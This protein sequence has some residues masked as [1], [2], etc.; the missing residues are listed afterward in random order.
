[1]ENVVAINFKLEMLRAYPNP[2]LAAPTDV[3][4]RALSRIQIL[5]KMNKIRST[6]Y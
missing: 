2:T 1:M 5:G 4:Y 3:I 6:R